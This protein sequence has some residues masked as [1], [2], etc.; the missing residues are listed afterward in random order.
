MININELKNSFPNSN[1]VYLFLLYH[2]KV[3]SSEHCKKFYNEINVTYVTLFD[4][5]EEIL[6]KYD[7]CNFCLSLNAERIPMYFVSQNKFEIKTDV[8]DA[9]GTMC[10]FILD[11]YSIKNHETIQ[12]LDII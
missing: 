7:G 3:V 9:Y 10:D 1:P 4:T 12:L 8:L 6:K 5:L 2:Y 11:P